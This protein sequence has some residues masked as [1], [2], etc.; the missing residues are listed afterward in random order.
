MLKLVAPLAALAGIEAE[1]VISR[2]KGLAIIYSLI[3][4][5]ALVGA[6]FL[7]VAGH[8]L[9]AF[10]VGP[11]YSALILAAVFLLLAL[12][13]YLG[14]T[15]SEGRRQKKRAEKRRS[16]ES[17][18]FLTT[19]ALTALPLLARSPMLIKLGLPAAAIAAFVLLRDGD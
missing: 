2:F 9:L 6:I 16:S 7:L 10:Y 5:L 4:L 18:A 8:L 15:I 14:A 17:G 12:A 1:H 11:T 19:A 3:A 13:V